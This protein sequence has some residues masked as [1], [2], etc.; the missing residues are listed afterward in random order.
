[1]IMGNLRLFS[2]IFILVLNFS[3]SALA[4]GFDAAYAACRARL[5][6]EYERNQCYQLVSNSCAMDEYAVK[7]CQK[8]FDTYYFRSCM[9]SIASRTYKGGLV[10]ICFK[11][12]NMVEVNNCLVASGRYIPNSP[13]GC[14]AGYPMPQPPQP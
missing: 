7:R 5:G 11:R 14:P 4:D 13:W 10:D 8:V 2:G 6:N 9:N 1:M 3:S 12:L